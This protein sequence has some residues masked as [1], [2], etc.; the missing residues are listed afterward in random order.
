MQSL[1]DRSVHSKCGIEGLEEGRVAEWL[2]QALYGTQFEH[3]W[4]AVSFP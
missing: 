3:A 4:T 1:A 2:E